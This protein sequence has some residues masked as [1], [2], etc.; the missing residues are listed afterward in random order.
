MGKEFVHCRGP[1]GE[2]RVNPIKQ[3]GSINNLNKSL[4]ESVDDIG[5]A[6]LG[7]DQRR[8]ISPLSLQKILP[9]PINVVIE[10]GFP[11]Q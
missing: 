3:L 4:R 10:E 2:G 7:R 11:V 9:D 5:V 1:L 6:F 8:K